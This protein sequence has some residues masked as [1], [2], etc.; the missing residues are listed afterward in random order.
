MMTTAK[1]S[2]KRIAFTARRL[3]ACSLASYRLPSGWSHNPDTV[4]Q[5][6]PGGLGG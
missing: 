1:H 6:I 4:E 2:L 3:S 5:A